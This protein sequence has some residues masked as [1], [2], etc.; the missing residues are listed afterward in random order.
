MLR[1]DADWL[2]KRHLVLQLAAL[3]V[4]NNFTVSAGGAGNA[5]GEAGLARQAGTQGTHYL[6]VVW[7]LFTSSTNV[8]CSSRI[9]SGG[10]LCCEAASCRTSASSPRNP[11]ARRAYRPRPRES[12]TS[13]TSAWSAPRSPSPLSA[14]G[15]CD[16]CAAAAFLRKI[17]IPGCRSH[18]G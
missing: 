12:W 18:G 16:L 5:A 9:G 3:S 6:Q 14:C 2:L 10:G 13:A 8:P 15:W 11:W 1:Y 7:L 17:I 4:L